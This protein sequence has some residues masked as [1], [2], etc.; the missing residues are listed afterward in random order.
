MS[1]AYVPSKW[2]QRFHATVAHEILGGG[3][4]G[5]GK[6]VALTADPFAQFIV[7]H[8]RCKLPK[9]H[10]L[11]HP[12][13]RKVGG[14]SDSRCWALFLRRVGPML[15]QTIERAGR[16][17]RRLDPGVTYKALS[18]ESGIF[19]LS[20]GARYQFDSCKDKVSY[21]RF[22]GNEY[23]WIGFDE[24][25]Q[26]DELQ[27]FNIIR[28]CRTTDPVLAK[29]RRR[30]SVG[31]PVLRR[32]GESFTVDNPYWVRDYFVDPAPSG[33]V[34][35]KR[36]VEMHD[37]STET[38]SRIFIP[39]LLWDNPDPDFVKQ[40]EL[41]LRG[42]GGKEHIIQALLTGNWYITADTFYDDYDPTVH[43]VKPF[44]VPKGWARFRTM[45]WGYKMPG[46]VQWWAQNPDED[47]VI[48]REWMFQGRT[49]RE[50]AS[51]IRAREEEMGLWGK[52]GSKITGPADNQIW[53]ERGEHA[54]KTKA[55]TFADLGVPWL[56]A[57]KGPGSRK[58]HAHLLIQKLRDKNPVSPGFRIFT[59]CPETHKNIASI[60][61]D[62]NDQECPLDTKRDHPHD[63]VL[64]GVA[65][66]SRGLES[67]DSEDDDDQ[68]WRDT[69]EVDP[70][71]ASYGA[72]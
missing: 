20:S 61:T 71:L 31:N 67:N 41:E 60:P 51:G 45:D 14:G 4:A 44:Q 52:E 27:Y 57:E 49:D 23:T 59:T 3:S 18:S 50:V 26:F 54:V 62:P 56:K 25:P 10:P 40:Y 32:E 38:W 36:K 70:Y 55:E 12:F 46:I 43:F 63:G 1:D 6:S 39:A 47:L 69:Y 9:T 11:Y 5:C 72:P 58:R 2:G 35:I 7:E 21:E 29:M 28:R 64:Y 68:S 22:M 34:K 53:E 24:L 13:P 48:M 37:G 65:H 42:A 30:C 16:M 19:H 17:L 15:P 66:A 33:N 8:E